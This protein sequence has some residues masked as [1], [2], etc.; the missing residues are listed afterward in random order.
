MRAVYKTLQRRH[1]YGAI[2]HVGGLVSGGLCS[3]VSR[4]EADAWGHHFCIPQGVL[5]SLQWASTHHSFAS[6]PP[7]IVSP[8]LHREH[9]RS[10]LLQCVIQD[11]SERIHRIVLPAWPHSSPF[12]NRGCVDSDH[13]SYVVEVHGPLLN[14]LHAPVPVIVSHP[15]QEK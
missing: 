2:S 5:G 6:D 4:P 9:E 3:G 8:A 12:W 1:N 10:T 14:V 11:V 15:L 13:V 7:E